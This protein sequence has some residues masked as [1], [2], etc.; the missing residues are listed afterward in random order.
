MVSSEGL[1]AQLSP[2]SHVAELLRGLAGQVGKDSK[3]EEDLYETYLCWAKIKTATNSIAE[4][5]IGELETYIADLA[6]GRFEL[7]TE[8]VDLEKDVKNLSQELE[9]MK[10]QRNKEKEDF[11]EA[12]EEMDQAIGESRQGS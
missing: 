5:L 2:T 3:K 9:A 11:E 1:R 10:S 4:S 7:T 6:A 12:K 8:R